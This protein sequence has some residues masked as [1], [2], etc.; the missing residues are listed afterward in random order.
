MSH[1][2]KQELDGAR[3]QLQEKMAEASTYLQDN[4]RLRVGFRLRVTYKLASCIW[5]MHLEAVHV[6]NT[7]RGS[8]V[9]NLLYV[10][11]G[12]GVGGCINYC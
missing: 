2:S 9:A 4:E 12:A 11:Y 1:D 3:E 7:P 10:L 5:Q 6:Y 8:W